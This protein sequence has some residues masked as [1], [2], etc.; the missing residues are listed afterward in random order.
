MA[1]QK[2]ALDPRTLVDARALRAALVALRV[3]RAFLNGPYGGS[4]AVPPLLSRRVPARKNPKLWAK[5]GAALMAE[6]GDFLTQ[7]HYEL[8]LVQLVNV[9]VEDGELEALFRKVGADKAGKRRAI[10]ALKVVTKKDASAGR[11]IA[12]AR[13]ALGAREQ[14]ERT[15]IAMERGVGTDGGPVIALPAEAVAQWEFAVKEY[16]N[17]SPSDNDP[18]EVAKVQKKLEGAKVRLAK[19]GTKAV[20]P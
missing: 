16:A 9:D 12:R 3:L 7:P 1:A 2:D 10:L 20:K 11:R 15:P 14:P 19:E 13:A 18:L 6:A 4:M 17:G 8:L 5:E